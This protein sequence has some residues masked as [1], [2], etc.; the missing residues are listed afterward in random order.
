[1]MDGGMAQGRDRGHERVPELDDVAI[2]ERD[3]LEGNT[4]A[5]GQVA[6]R[7]GP[8]DERGRPGDVARLQAA[9][10]KPPTR[11]TGPDSRRGSP[12]AAAASTR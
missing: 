3:V 1:V 11:G 7:A 8:L 2:G 9:G 5:G 4:G 6:G 12:A 10:A